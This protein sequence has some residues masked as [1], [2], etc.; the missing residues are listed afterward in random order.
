MRHPHPQPKVLLFPVFFLIFQIIPVF[1]SPESTQLGL[2]LSPGGQKV[3]LDRAKFTVLYDNEL[4][5]PVWVAEYL[6]R[7]DVE[8]EAV[9]RDKFSFSDD[10][11]IEGEGESWTRGMQD[12]EIWAWGPL[13]H[14][15]LRLSSSD[16]VCPN[17]VHPSPSFGCR[18]IT[19]L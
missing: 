1:G 3:L 5:N 17:P 19:G 16:L 4:N 2:P 6:T 13:V 12:S 18:V 14:P 8:S 9:S 7:E 11:D 15:R 10:P